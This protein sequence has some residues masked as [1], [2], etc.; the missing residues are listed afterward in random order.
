M[1]GTVPLL[2]LTR[3]NIVESVHFGALAVMDACGSLVASYGNPDLVTFMRSSAKPFQA[4]PFIEAEGDVHFKLTPREVA[5]MCA[6]HSGTDEHFNVVSGIQKK[7]K[8]KE[9]E[10]LCGTHW[11]MD[12]ATEHAMR[13]RGETPTPNRHNCSGKHTGF[14]SHA[15]LRGFS[16]E[17]YINLE[18][19]LQKIILQ[20]IA[21]MSDMKPEA[22][23]MGVDGCS[24]PVHAMP[25]RNAALA[26]ARLADPSN[27]APARA[28]ACQRI[29]SAMMANGDMVGGPGRFDTMLMAALSGRVTAKGGAEGFQGMAIMPGALG[30]GS[31][32]LGV[33][34]KISDGDLKGRAIPAVALEVLRQLGVLSEADL[35]ALADFGPRKP[36]LNWRKLV[37]GEMRPIFS[38]EN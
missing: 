15:A 14:L 29:T 37:V 36:V 30:A 12:E 4:L 11:P 35:Q 3:G 20:T 28:A 19:P 7:V 24:A 8:L 10:L 21:E 6:S 33:A 23:E 5:I 32:G 26:Y 13:A 2:E 17:D 34:I 16:H 38:L 27:L 22:I 25:L 18:H 31:P 1:T 9:S